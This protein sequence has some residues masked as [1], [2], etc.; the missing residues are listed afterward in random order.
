[1]L[2]VEYSRKLSMMQIGMRGVSAVVYLPVNSSSSSHPDSPLKYTVLSSHPHDIIRLLLRLHDRRTTTWILYP[3]TT[4][5]KV[6]QKRLRRKKSLKFGYTRNCRLKKTTFRTFLKD[7][8]LGLIC[9]S[10]FVGGK[11]NM[12]CK[13]LPTKMRP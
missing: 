10:L 12:I 8:I 5:T 11:L 3:S 7:K 6:S 4:S 1:M 9:R 2:D 13:G